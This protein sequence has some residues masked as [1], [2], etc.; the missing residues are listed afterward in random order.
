MAKQIYTGSCFSA[1]TWGHQAAGVTPNEMIAIERNALACSGVSP[2]G[3]C[4]LISLSVIYGPGGTRRLELS[5]TQLKC[6]SRFL[7]STVCKLI[8]LI[9]LGLRLEGDWL[10]KTNHNN[11]LCLLCQMS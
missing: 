11:M 8:I 4:R 10:H 2:I 5:K 7:P 1:S 3:R 6:G 9:V